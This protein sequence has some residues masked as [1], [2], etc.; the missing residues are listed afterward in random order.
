M[1]FNEKTKQWSRAHIFYNNMCSLKPRGDIPE[2]A[3][4]EYGWRRRIFNEAPN[5]KLMVGNSL[6]D[7]LRN[8]SK[9]HLIHVTTN[10][11][12][13]LSNRV[14]YPSSGCLLG[15]IYTSLL[16]EEGGKFRVHNLGRYIIEEEAPRA[17]YLKKQKS[18]ATLIIE[19]VL[20]PNE[21]NHLIGIDYTRLGDIHLGIYRE[22]EKLT[23]SQE[24]H[25]LYEIVLNKIRCSLTFLRLISESRIN[26]KRIKPELFFKLYID[27]VDRL[28]FL[29]Y[30]Y[31]EAV[32]E[33]LMLYQD[34]EKA[35]RAHAIGELYNYSYKNLMYDLFPDLLLSRG[36]SSFKPT[37]KTLSD[38]IKGKK[39][40][41]RFDQTT[42]SSYLVDRCTLLINTR[43]LSTSFHPINWHGLKWNFDFMAEILPS[44]VG[45]LIYRELK[46]RSSGPNLDQFEAFQVWNYWNY[47]NVVVPF[48]GFIPKGEIGINPAYPELK[49]QIY[50]G[51]PNKCGDNLYIAQDKKLD[52][53]IMPRLVSRKY[54]TMRI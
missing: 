43:L 6:F 33:Y 10:L 25:R 51:V 17:S 32:S 34:S 49:Y 21:H 26:F 22:F 39:I 46:N 47:M 15:G 42:M 31:F 11:D 12:A 2:E 38:Y 53:K 27:A 30:L 45:H 4:L 50:L 16:F 54:T 13:I 28:P 8:H 5:G 40:I 1:T 14:L 24:K 7:N 52:I 48:N 3:R 18:P 41:S 35:K 20:P 9:I 19:I 29:G 37:P 36:L 23:S 44:L